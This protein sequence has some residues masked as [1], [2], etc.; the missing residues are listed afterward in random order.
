MGRPSL[1]PRTLFGARLHA[2]RQAAGLSQAEAAAHLGLTQTAYAAW[3]RYSVALRPEQIEAVAHL[4][5]I[6]VKDLFSKT[7]R[8]FLQNGPIG[9]ARRAFETVSRLPRRQ[10]HDI[11]DFVDALIKGS[12]IRAQRRAAARSAKTSKAANISPTS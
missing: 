4:F 2:A 12:Q 7:P 8:A 5:K 11:L 1:E 9:R 3:E 10:Q 6:P